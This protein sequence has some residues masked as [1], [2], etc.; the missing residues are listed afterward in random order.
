MASTASSS[1]S[2][3]KITSMSDQLV[4]AASRSRSGPTP[5]ASSFVEITI[6]TSVFP[7]SEPPPPLRLHRGI[8][9][10]SENYA[11]N[12]VFR[13]RR[14]GRLPP[15][16]RTKGDAADREPL[17]RASTLRTVTAWQRPVFRQGPFVQHGEYRWLSSLA[18]WTETFRPP[19]GAFRTDRD[20]GR[21]RDECR[22]STIAAAA[23]PPRAADTRG[24][25][26]GTHPPSGIES[27]SLL[28]SK[29]A[30]AG[31]FQRIA[32]AYDRIMGWYSWQLASRSR[33]LP[34]SP[35]ACVCS[36]SG[37]YRGHTHQLVSRVG[38]PL[39][40]AA[41]RPPTTARRYGRATRASRSSGHRRRSCPGRT[42]R[43]RRPR[44]AR[45]DVHDRCAASHARGGRVLRRLKVADCM[46]WLTAWT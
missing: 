22:L 33:T 6:E 37:G 17:P 1:P 45:R 16:S 44:P 15:L 24:R 7:D 18:P 20:V 40:A 3:T 36:T 23:V 8:T 5:S 39:V 32:D 30:R 42:T 10:G 29:P 26:V 19:A 11:R 9:D 34:G 14:H 13:R 27:P 35:Q 41:S 38:E 12:L 25:A 28:G 2:S 31:R 46:W 4:T 43:R 21:G